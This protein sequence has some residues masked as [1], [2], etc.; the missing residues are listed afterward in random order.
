MRWSPIPSLRSHD[1]DLIVDLPLARVPE[2]FGALKGSFYVDESEMTRAVR[3]ARAFNILHLARFEKLDLFVAG[4]D[5][6]D[7]AQLEQ[8]MLR[9]LHADSERCFP[10]TAPEVVVVRKLDWYRRGDR[11]SDRQWRDVLAVLRVQGGRLDRARMRTLAQASGL[12]ALL[13]EAFVAA[14]SGDAPA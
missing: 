1:V 7:V 6:L 9:T 11:V 5:P 3:S 2:L 12:E 4:T 13:D 8:P 14:W 10:V